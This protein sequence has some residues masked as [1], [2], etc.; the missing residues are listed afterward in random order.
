MRPGKIRTRRPLWTHEALSRVR[1]VFT[2]GTCRLGR[3]LG[4]QIGSRIG[5]V[6]GG[7]EGQGDGIVAVD[8][9]QPS[10][11]KNS[12][13]RYEL[14][15]AG[16][17]PIPTIARC[18]GDMG[19]RPGRV[20]SVKLDARRLALRAGFHDGLVGFSEDVDVG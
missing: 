8:G 6:G 5:G 11:L 10:T 20:A 18:H 13:S 17:R 7:G 1:V 4:Y 15:W 2:S 9:Q 16:E 14:A 19:D 12:L 3:V